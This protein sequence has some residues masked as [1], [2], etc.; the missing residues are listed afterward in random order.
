MG[1]F[2]VKDDSQF[3]LLIRD[4]NIVMVCSETYLG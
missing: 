4:F 1:H 3:G 2:A